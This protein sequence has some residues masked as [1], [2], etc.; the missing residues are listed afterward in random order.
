MGIEQNALTFLRDYRRA[1]QLKKI[2]LR[3]E[4]TFC[5][6]CN[7]YCPLFRPPL[8]AKVMFSSELHP[9]GRGLHAHEPM[10]FND[11]TAPGDKIQRRQ[12]NK[13]DREREIIRKELSTPG[14]WLDQSIQA[15]F[16]GTN[17]T[18][19]LITSGLSVNWELKRRHLD[20]DSA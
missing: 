13:Q 2:Y 4:Q 15:R 6:P 3:S 7:S 19:E 14:S 17:P 18:G 16:L 12:N 1:A 10:Y 9:Q 11:L 5:E 8:S 20:H